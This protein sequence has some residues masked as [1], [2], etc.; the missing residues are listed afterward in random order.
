MWMQLQDSIHAHENE[1]GNK[2]LFNAN[3]R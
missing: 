3:F 1:I 2:L